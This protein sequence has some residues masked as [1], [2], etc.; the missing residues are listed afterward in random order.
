[1]KRPIYVDDPIEGYNFSV[2]KTG[3]KKET[4]YEFK[5]DPRPTPISED[6][7]EIEKMLTLQWDLDRI[8][9]FPK[10]EKLAEYANIAL[11]FGQFM[12]SYKGAP[13]RQAPA[14]EKA[15]QRREIQGHK[16]P[17]TSPSL[18]SI[19]KGAVGLGAPEKACF[20]NW[21]N[22]LDFCVEC[23]IEDDCKDRFKK[24]GPAT[25]RP[26]PEQVAALEAEADEAY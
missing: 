14:A 20:G 18:V 19:G 11:K 5:F 7:A 25:K 10:D 13:E 6:P 2:K 16:A 1:L 15:A 8:N 21:K 24:M 17:P 23:S 26:T 9:K 12:R 4:R 3:V 22:G